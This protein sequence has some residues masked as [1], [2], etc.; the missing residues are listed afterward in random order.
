MGAEGY[1]VQ[2]IAL[3]HCHP[4]VA[5]LARMT[6]FDSADRQIDCPS[7]VRE[8]LPTTLNAAQLDQ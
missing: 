1:S 8:L 5:L 4:G 2:T 3:N 7:F 6:D